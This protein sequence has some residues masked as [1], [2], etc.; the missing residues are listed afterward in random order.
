MNPVSVRRSLT[1]PRHL[2]VTHLRELMQRSGTDASQSTRIPLGRS[3]SR[4]GLDYIVAGAPTPSELFLRLTL[5]TE[6]KPPGDLDEQNSAGFAAAL[7]IGTGN[8]AGQ[9]RGWVREEG[10]A[11]QP[12]DS[13]YLPGNGMDR[14]R[15]SGQD[16]PFTAADAANTPD[17]PRVKPEEFEGMSRTIGALGP[18]TFLRLTGLRYGFVGLGRL[19]SNLLFRLVETSGLRHCV[20]VDPDRVELHNTGESLL[21][22]ESSIGVPKVHAAEDWLA[23][24]HPGV[25]VAALTRSITHGEAIAALKGC[26]ILVSAPDHSGARLAA[27]AIASAYN[28]VLLDIGTLVSRDGRLGADVRLI[29]NERCLLCFGGVSDEGR[30]RASLASPDRERSDLHDRD[31]RSE[32]AGS[33]DSLNDL[34]ACAGR[35]LVERCVAGQQRESVWLQFDET[36]EFPLRVS[37]PQPALERECFCSIAG[38]GDAGIPRILEVLERRAKYHA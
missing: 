25:E 12:L 13:L 8:I 35:R 18:E 33:L 10:G 2:L 3:W 31:W 28:R 1:Y 19:N 15:L 22:D 38:W 30:G 16:H 5:A 6:F 27:S 4:E 11:W 17:G 24:H 32:R 26:D 23:L 37:Q 9:A 7:T 21:F 36:A 29:L 14:V 20:L 34:A